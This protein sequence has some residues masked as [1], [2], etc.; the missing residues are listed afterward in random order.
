MM[1]N[2]REQNVLELIRTSTMKQLCAE[3][4]KLFQTVRCIYS[5]SLPLCVPVEVLAVLHTFPLPCLFQVGARDAVT[6]NSLSGRDVVAS[7]AELGMCLFS[8]DLACLIL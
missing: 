6:Y 1:L 5:S 8:F 4:S 3:S 7:L 2:L